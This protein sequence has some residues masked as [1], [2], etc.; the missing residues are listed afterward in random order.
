MQCDIAIRIQ[1]HNNASFTYISMQA[2][3][4]VFRIPIMIVVL[5]YKNSCYCNVIFSKHTPQQRTGVET[6]VA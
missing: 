5:Y 3:I 6:N 2:R 1:I 4:R